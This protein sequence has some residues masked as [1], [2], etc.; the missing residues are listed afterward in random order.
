MNNLDDGKRKKIEEVLKLLK[1]CKGVLKTK[2]LTEEEKR[3]ILDVEKKEEEEIVFGMC[4]SINKGVREALQ[5]EFTVATVINSSVF[6]YPHHPH[7]VMVIED[8]I[9][10]EQ[11]ND[12]KIIEELKK[13]PMNL[14]LWNRFVIYVKKLPKES[15]ERKKLRMVYLPRKPSQL[16]CLSFLSKCCFGVP[17]TKGDSLLKKILNNQSNQTVLGTCLVGFDII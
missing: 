2:T 10:G 4:K 14:F 15:T 13:D 3:E 11:I 8:Q 17:S 7:M 1:G 5:R 9:V 6:E 12:Q 16:D